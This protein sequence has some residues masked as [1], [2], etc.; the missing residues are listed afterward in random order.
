MFTRPRHSADWQTSTPAWADVSFS[1]TPH[2]PLLMHWPNYGSPF[3]H[4][5]YPI[6]PLSFFK[7]IT[8]GKTN[9]K[10][11]S[12]TDTKE[13]FQLGQQVLQHT[14]LRIWRWPTDGRMPTS[15][16]SRCH[17]QQMSLSYKH[18]KRAIKK[19]TQ[20]VSPQSI[21]LSCSLRHSSR[22]ICIMK[23]GQTQR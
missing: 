13:Y 20:C 22:G 12:F 1:T 14:N 2:P 16:V 8:Y 17:L 10:I 7:N 23:S 18:A 5:L 6:L 3:C 4:T 19:E 15:W 9:N 21:D 11:K